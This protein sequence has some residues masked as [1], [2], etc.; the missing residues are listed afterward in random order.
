MAFDSCGH[1][2]EGDDF[3]LSLMVLTFQALPTRTSKFH[4]NLDI[5]ISKQ[6]TLHLNSM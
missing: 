4:S 3:L 1:D 6:L 5:C 2:Y